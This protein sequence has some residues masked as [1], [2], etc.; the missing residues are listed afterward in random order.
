MTTPL[1]QQPRVTGEGEE[2]DSSF[3]KSQGAA[4]VWE[5]EGMC[6]YLVSLADPQHRERALGEDTCLDVVLRRGL[7]WKS[8]GKIQ[9]ELGVL[10]SERTII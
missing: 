2:R 8:L 7:A 4:G 10:Q 6:C 3:L 9:W 5:S 1:P